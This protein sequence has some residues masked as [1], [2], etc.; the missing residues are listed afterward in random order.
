MKRDQLLASIEKFL[1]LYVFA[2]IFLVLL[3][4]Y[5]V[6]K[7]KPA[8]TNIDEI[9]QSIVIGVSLD[10]VKN[11]EIYKEKADKKIEMRFTKQDGKWYIPTHFNCNGN[12]SR[13]EQIIKDMLEMQGKVQATGEH[14]FDRFEIDDHQGIHILLKDEADKA[15]ANLIIGKKGEDYGTSFVR[16]AGRDKIFSADK[17]I[18][19][20]LRIYGEVDTLTTFKVN[21]FVNLTAVE[22]EKDDLVTIGLVQKGKGITLKRE[23][24]EVKVET[25]EADSVSAEP[26][27]KSENFWAITEPR[28]IELDQKEVEKCL[29]DIR[30]ISGQKVVDRIGDNLLTDS[31]KYSTYGLNNPTGYI[32][33]FTEDGSRTDVRFGR[34][35]EKDKGYYFMNQNDGLVYEVTKFNY[36]RIFK[37][38]KDLPEKKK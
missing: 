36:D 19:S 37:W 17:N 28:R 20:T 4:V 21:N 31:G 30:R 11:I 35:F 2:S 26:E 8:S 6:T 22:F 13:I 14:L 16:F 10:D 32:A 12:A 38:I 27:M 24:R 29:N 5:F 3:V 7:P 9:Q 33:F 18:I 15:L 34:E 23:T 25:T 1:I